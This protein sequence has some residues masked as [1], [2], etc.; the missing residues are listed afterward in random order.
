MNNAELLNSWKEIAIY[1]DRGVRTVQRWEAEL[2]LPVRRPR[3]KARSAV[4]ALKQEL[5]GWLRQTPAAQAEQPAITRQS[6]DLKALV[7]N[8]GRMLVQMQ[9][10]C[11]ASTRMQEL[12]KSAVATA[13]RR[14]NAAP[15]SEK[16]EKYPEIG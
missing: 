1:L 6:H 15:A 8:R 4:L 5:D 11:L 3:G 16:A 13:H 2:G 14:E 10:L 7:A 9:Q 12:V